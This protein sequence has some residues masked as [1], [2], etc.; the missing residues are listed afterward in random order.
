MQQ[1]QLGLVCRVDE[2]ALNGEEAAVFATL[3]RRVQHGGVEEA[4]GPLLTAAGTCGSEVTFSL[5]HRIW[6]S[7]GVS[8]V[9]THSV[10]ASRSVSSRRAPS[11]PDPRT[12]TAPFWSHTEQPQRVLKQNSAARTAAGRGTHLDEQVDTETGAQRKP[13][14]VLLQHQKT[15]RTALSCDISDHVTCNVISVSHSEEQSRW[16]ESRQPPD[17]QRQHT[18]TPDPT[19]CTVQV[20]G[21]APTHTHTHNVSTCCG[22]SS[23]DTGRSTFQQD[24]PVFVCRCLC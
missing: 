23:W 4:S 10:D 1:V 8:S 7:V 5:E 2:D 12:N 16:F 20:C 15:N 3:G 6:D 14:G 11:R 9:R 21:H 24:S 22:H 19:H 13:S 18:N 17:P